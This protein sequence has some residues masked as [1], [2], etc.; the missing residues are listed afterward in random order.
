[1]TPHLQ[2]A[3]FQVDL[4]LSTMTLINIQ[5]FILQNVQTGPAA[6][7]SSC[8]MGTGFFFAEGK[9]AGA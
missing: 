3:T 7:K 6:H 4:D 9:V 2:T 5:K 8:P 1:M